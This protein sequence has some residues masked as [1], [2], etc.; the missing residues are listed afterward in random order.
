MKAFYPTLCENKILEKLFLAIYFN[1]L[2]KVIEFKTKHPPIYA[3]KS[4]FLI[5]NQTPFDLTSLTLFH[6]K[7]WFSDE[8]RDQIKSLID[9][10]RQRTK[11]LGDFWKTEGIIQDLDSTFAYNQ[12]WNYFN[13]DDPDDY[14]EVMFEPIKNYLKNGF[15]EIDLQLYNRVE[16]L[17]CTNARKL[18]KQGAKADIHFQNDGDSSAFSHIVGAVSYLSTTQVIPQFESFYQRAP[19]QHFDITQMFANLIGLASHEE[20]YRLLQKYYGAY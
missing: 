9:K 14:E 8:W 20:M 11:Q 4:Y 18:L 1:D 17:D 5:E 7:I 15:R 10:S 16:C 12:F 6:Y 3:K 19:D 13:C 2:D